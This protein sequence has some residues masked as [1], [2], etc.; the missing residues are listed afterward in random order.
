MSTELFCALGL[1]SH[2]IAVLSEMSKARGELVT[3][4]KYFQD[5]P[6]KA[7]TAIISAI[8]GYVVLQQ[9]GELTLLTAFGVGVAANDFSDRSGKIAMKKLI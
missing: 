4:L 1:L 8:I 2:L 7:A 5:R 6:Y 3:P 9:S